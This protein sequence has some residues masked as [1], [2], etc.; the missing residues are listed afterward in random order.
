[1][2]TEVKR[3]VEACVVSQTTKY[4]T[5]KPAGLL[6]PVPIP[7]Q[8]WDDVSMDFI[9]GLPQSRGYTTIMVVV[10]RLSKY[11]HFAPLPARFDALKVAHLFINTVVRH[12]GFPKSLVSDRDSVFLN[13]VWEDLLR[14]SGT[15]LNFF[16]HL[17]PAVR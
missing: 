10:D 8:V 12:H 9:T 6:Q 13:Q 7:T 17:S 4:S 16:D 15:K 5:Q 3:F 2:K 11:A 1:M 14:L